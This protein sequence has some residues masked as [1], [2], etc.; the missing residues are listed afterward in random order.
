MRTVFTPL[1]SGLGLLIALPALAAG[2][3]LVGRITRP[4]EIRGVYEANDQ[5]IPGRTCGPL[6]HVG[7]ASYVVDFGRNEALRQ[8]AKRQDGKAVIITGIPG[9]F[10]EVWL[11][12]FA[13]VRLPVIY[14]RD[15][16]PTDSEVVGELR[17]VWRDRGHGP[18]LVWEVRA[19]GKV[20][21]LDH[22]YSRYFH[23]LV[24][25]LNGKMVRVS[26]IIEHRMGLHSILDKNGVAIMSAPIYYDAIVVSYPEAFRHEPACG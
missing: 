18:V 6:L 7:K 11:G 19:G 16:R 20:Y 2:P 14:V 5:N 17:Q 22:P 1:L 10:R 8:A 13:K 3:A 12:C 4:V 24:T 26:G 15:V 21:E 9:G 25:K 23:R